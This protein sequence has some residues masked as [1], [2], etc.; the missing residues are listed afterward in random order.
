MTALYCQLNQYVRQI[1]KSISS[2]AISRSFHLYRYTPD[3]PKPVIQTPAAVTLP[4]ISSAEIQPCKNDTICKEN[5]LPDIDLKYWRSCAEK[6]E[7][8]SLSTPIPKCRFMN[9]T[10]RAAVALASCPGSG[11]TWVRGL[12]EQA[13]G[14]CTGECYS[15][16]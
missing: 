3:K 9:G 2:P 4:S 11:N 10:H 1:L 16:S 5:L 7:R 12:L 15:V 13:T 8:W 14:I 6:F